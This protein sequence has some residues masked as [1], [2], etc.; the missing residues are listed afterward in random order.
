[1][2]VS[3][4]IADGPPSRLVEQAVDGR[5]ELVLAAPVLSEL[6]R[7]LTAKLGFT[8]E[9]WQ[10]AEDVLLEIGASAGTAPERVQAISGDPDDDVILA[11]AFANEVDVI[12]SGDR[13]HLLPL[14]AHRGIPILT[15]QALLLELLDTPPHEPHD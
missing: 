13:R 1:M 11:W 4:A 6:E 2:L 9:R 8:A 10:E 14:R 3:A 12:A 15:P 7:V 5:I